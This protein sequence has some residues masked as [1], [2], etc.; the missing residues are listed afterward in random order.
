MDSALDLRIVP[1]SRQRALI[2]DTFDALSPG[3]TLEIVD[4]HDP[5]PL[6]FRLDRLREGQFA[7]RYLQT[8]PECW[9]VRIARVARHS[10]GELPEAPA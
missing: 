1:L 6:Y 3:E 4:D 9:R 7:W 5:M 10:G 2:F 8:G